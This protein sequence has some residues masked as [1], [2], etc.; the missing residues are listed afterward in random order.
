MQ[1]YALERLECIKPRSETMKFSY[2]VELVGVER[3]D[4]GHNDEAMTVRRRS[5]DRHKPGFSAKPGLMTCQTRVC[6][7]RRAVVALSSHRRHVVVKQSSCRR[8]IAV[9]PSAHRR[10]AAKLS[11]SGRRHIVV[12]PSSPS[13]YRLVVI[14]HISLAHVF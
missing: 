9:V 14:F 8:S 2:L 5:D 6:D 13:S 4:D 1:D 10:R 12:V 3:H 11:S 7:G